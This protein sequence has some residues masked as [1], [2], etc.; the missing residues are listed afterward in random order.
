MR[1]ISALLTLLSQKKFK[2]LVET[3]GFQLVNGAVV[4]AGFNGAGATPKK[5]RAK[6]K[7]TPESALKKRKLEETED[8]EAAGCDTMKNEAGADRT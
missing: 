8:A 6:A 3:A 1:V 4:A 5:P 7:K 2:K